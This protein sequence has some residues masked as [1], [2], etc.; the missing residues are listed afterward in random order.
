MR[1]NVTRQ[2]ARHHYPFFSQAVYPRSAGLEY[3]K[4]LP[5]RLDL[6]DCAEADILLLINTDGYSDKTTAECQKRIHEA[7][8]LLLETRAGSMPTDLHERHPPVCTIS[9]S[10]AD[11][12]ELLCQHGA[13]PAQVDLATNAFDRFAYTS[14]LEPD[15]TG[16]AL[17]SFEAYA[18]EM[19]YILKR[20]EKQGYRNALHI[21]SK[22]NLL[23]HVLYGP[24]ALKKIGSCNEKNFISELSITSD[25]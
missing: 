15:I 20:Y 1:R 11:V 8:K 2:Y 12:A 21:M 6:I 16:F 5:K 10:I 3:F 18:A 7:V 9:Y 17:Q 23:N 25:V 19:Y 24:Q 14:D 22:Q 13:D 4:R